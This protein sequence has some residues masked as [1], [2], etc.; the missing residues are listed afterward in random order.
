MIQKLGKFIVKARYWFFGLFIVLAIASVFFMQ[1][2]GVNYNMVEYLP[3]NSNTKIS[4]KVME[5]EFGSS[6]SA[7]IMISG[8]S[9]EQAEILASD[10]A[11]VE[12]VASAVFDASNASYY[13]VENQK[14]LIKVFLS[15]SDYSKEAETTLNNIENTLNEKSAEFALSGSAVTAIN[16]RNAVGSE[17]A[18]ILLVAIVIVLAIL[19]LTSRS[20]IEPLIFLIVIGVAIL[21]NM[22]TNIFLGEISFITKSISS[23]MLIAL[24]MDYSIVL[25]HR[26]REEKQKNN[27]SLIAMEKAIAGSFMAVVSSSFTVMAGLVAL[28][29]MDFS[30]GFD[31]GMVLA[32]G[33]FIS[34]LAVLFFMPAV[35]LMFDKVIEKTSHKSFLPSMKKIGTFA[36]KTRFVMPIIFL[37]LIVGAVCLQGN[38]AFTYVVQSGTNDSKVAIAERQVEENFGKQNPLIIMLDKDE[39]EKQKQ[40][41]N[42]IITYKDKDGNEIINSSSVLALSSAYDEM[43]ANDIVSMGL[44]N[45]TASDIFASLGKSTEADKVCKIDVVKYLVENDTVLQT[46]F[47]DKI[48]SAYSLLFSAVTKSYAKSNYALSDDN[49]AVLYGEQESMP[50]CAVATYI[51]ENNLQ[52][53]SNPMIQLIYINANKTLSANDLMSTYSLS[54]EQVESL[55]SLF[56]KDVE[57]DSIKYYEIVDLLKNNEQVASLIIMAMQNNFESALATFVSASEM[58]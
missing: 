10:V 53:K 36:K 22:G 27:D 7:S 3:N 46:D 43:T 54:K 38:M 2:V 12:G 14:A 1:F 37:C 47:N 16:N 30:I 19:F 51:I 52:A 44:S 42:F 56:G 20:Y 23:V 15:N 6:G 40:I 39:I 58:L 29:F 55:F 11:R 4:I 17:M 26:F 21:I 25:L 50:L 8:V 41:A 49:I 13:N 24:E 45:A 57:V 28:M 5:D 33:V 34:V 32:K 48:D 18:V 31:I 35:I 9:K